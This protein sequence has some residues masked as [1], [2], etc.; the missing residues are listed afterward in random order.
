MYGGERIHV[1]DLD[2]ERGSTPSPAENKQTFKDLAFE[3]VKSCE[4][5]KNQSRFLN[6]Y[7]EYSYAW[8]TDTP[9]QTLRLCLT[10]ASYLYS[11][12]RRMLKQTHA[13]MVFY[14]RNGQ[15]KPLWL[16]H[17]F[18]SGKSYTFLNQ[19]KLLQIFKKLFKRVKIKLGALTVQNVPAIAWKIETNEGIFYIPWHSGA[20]IEADD[21][22]TFEE[23]PFNEMKTFY[24]ILRFTSTLEKGTFQ[25]TCC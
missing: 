12:L 20:I 14:N 23:K 6:V 4:H 15:F 1:L 2:V 25:V 7:S 18:K 17:H 3:E 5:E 11:P 19:N 24:N 10:G 21:S 8:H 16:L 22:F 13:L 9:D